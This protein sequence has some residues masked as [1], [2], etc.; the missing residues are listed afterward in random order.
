MCEYIPIDGRRSFREKIF[1]LAG[2][3]KLARGNPE[4]AVMLEEP[5]DD[6][7]GATVD[8]DLE[9]H[10]PRRA[11]EADENLPLLGN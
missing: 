10:W 9:K 2:N 4:R 6:M 5:G 8:P 1:I 3:Q 11:G 7:V